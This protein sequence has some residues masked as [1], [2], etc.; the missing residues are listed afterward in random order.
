MWRQLFIRD[1]DHALSFENALEDLITALSQN[2]LHA[3]V[4]KYRCQGAEAWRTHFKSNRSAERAR[5]FVK[6]LEGLASSFS[7]CQLHIEAINCQREVV[8]I[9]LA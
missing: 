6:A 3:V 5:G 7:Q 1:F 9:W 2:Q 8:D 4:I